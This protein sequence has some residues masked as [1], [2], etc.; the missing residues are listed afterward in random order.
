MR[1]WLK[2]SENGFTLVELLVA[3][4]II[5]LLGLAMGG[6]LIQLLRSD[7]ITQGMTA[8]RQVQAAGDRVSQ[9]G[10][11]AQ[12]VT[13]GADNM[14]SPSWYLNLSWTGEWMDD[15]GDFVLRSENV[16]YTLVPFNGQYNLQRHEI[17]QITVGTAAPTNTDLTSIVGR[18][19]DRSQ[20]SC[21]WE[22]INGD[23]EL[24][25]ITFAFKVVSVVGTKTEERTYN[26]TPRPQH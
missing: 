10:V 5:G 13:F 2:G 22:D 24:E 18:Y 19:L 25:E 11:Q 1:K 21:Q 17:S 6:V 7:R 20:M 3:I 26:I 4:P 9:D 23:G 15:S 12:Y 16:T 8:V 14:T